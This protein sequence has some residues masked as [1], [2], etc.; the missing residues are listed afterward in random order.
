MTTGRL[1]TAPR[2]QYASRMSRQISERLKRLARL[3]AR[4]LKE[5]A[6]LEAEMKGLEADLKELGFKPRADP[7]RPN[8]ASLN[9]RTAGDAAAIVLRN[10]KR[11]MR[12]V[13]IQRGIE[14]HGL[15][16]TE[17]RNLK[18][19]IATAPQEMRRGSGA[20]GRGCTS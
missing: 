16:R 19:T 5:V 14:R 8:A 10:A 4:L 11:L 2:L 7:P 3:R 9:E 15:Y 13:E 17:S 6:F 20:L 1:A 18:P 12:L